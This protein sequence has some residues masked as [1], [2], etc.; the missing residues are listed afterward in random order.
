MEDK[1]RKKR[2]PKKCTHTIKDSEQ[3]AWGWCIESENQ[4]DDMDNNWWSKKNSQIPNSPQMRYGLDVLSPIT[5]K[6]YGQ[7][8][9]KH[10][11]KR[12][13]NQCVD[14]TFFLYQIDQESHKG[15]N[16]RSDE[17]DKCY[18]AHT[19]HSTTLLEKMQKFPCFFH[20]FS[21]ISWS[22]FLT[23]PILLFRQE[24]FFPSICLTQ[25][26]MPSCHG[27]YVGQILR[28]QKAFSTPF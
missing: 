27:A 21:I 7:S 19:P 18:I 23:H 2:N 9:C 28:K 3:I 22:C 16:T 10:T 12:Y 8:E 14:G 6:K 17:S 20:G 13:L 4:V 11:Q 24:I 15:G 26:Y 25:K 5:C 1:T